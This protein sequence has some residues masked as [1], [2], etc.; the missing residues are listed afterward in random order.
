MSVRCSS[1]ALGFEFTLLQLGENY[2]DATPFQAA[3]VSMNM[4]LTVMA[5]ESEEAHIIY[6]ANLA[7]I[8][9]DQIVS[10]CGNSAAQAVNALRRA[11]GH[12]D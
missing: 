5:I 10:W 1:D 8:R 4:P 2:V 12:V 9:P 11:V 6:G 7:L 3:A